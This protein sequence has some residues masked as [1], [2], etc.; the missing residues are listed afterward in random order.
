[1]KLKV[2]DVSE[3]PRRPR[4]CRRVAQPRAQPSWSVSRAAAAEKGM[5]ACCS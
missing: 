3:L 5:A 1:M 2:E 4:A